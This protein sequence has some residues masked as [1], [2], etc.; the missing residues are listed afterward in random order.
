MLLL[1]IKFQ[2][3]KAF[4]L[5]RILIATLCTLIITGCSK[6]MPIADSKIDKNEYKLCI[7]TPKDTTKRILNIKPKYK[8]GMSLKPGKYHVE[9]SAK[10]H[11]TYRKWIDLQADKNLVVKLNKTVLI[12]KGYVNWKELNTIIHIDKYLFQNKSMDQSKK[13]S[14]DDANKYCND[15]V[16]KNHQQIY[17][18]FYLPSEIELKVLA[19]NITQLDSTVTISWSSTADSEHENFAKYVYLNNKKTGWYN[20]RGLSYAR[21]ISKVDYPLESSIF[22]LTKQIMREKRTA[23]L[24][25]IETAVNI[26][27]GKPIVENIKY[28]ELEQT[29][30]FSLKSMGRDLN[31]RNYYNKVHTL[32][33]KNRDPEKIKS[34][35]RKNPGIKFE[36]IN[37]KL[38][39][40]DIF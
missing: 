8:Y 18:D 21:C 30:H 17:D 6:Q 10:G 36:I 2:Y 3:I 28:D 29:I 31:K 4:Y 23:E 34:L 7:N 40:K 15:L 25:S 14:W 26:K 20:K 13:M 11:D 5:F 22:V 39:F 27:F 16:I 24:T 19:D 37:N 1:Y 12:S 38:L 9:I 35:L 32:S 33:I